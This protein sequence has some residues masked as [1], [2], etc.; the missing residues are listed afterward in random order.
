MQT[1]ICEREEKQGSA[2][3][4]SQIRGRARQGRAGLGLHNVSTQYRHGRVAIAKKHDR[5][6][7]SID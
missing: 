2:H 4:S 5:V 3:P 7:H 6:P 1:E